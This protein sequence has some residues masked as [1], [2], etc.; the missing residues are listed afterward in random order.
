MIKLRL[1][2][3]YLAQWRCVLPLASITAEQRNAL[4]KTAA[5]LMQR[6]V[7]QDCRKETVE[8]MKY[9]GA[10]AM[11]AGFGV[12]GQVAFRGLTSDPQVSRAFAGLDAFMDKDKMADLAK[13]AGLPP[14]AGK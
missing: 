5:Q 12:L 14:P 2:G 1:C 7:V 11:Q 10:S 6:L 4:D 8:A 3:G 9:E 13:E